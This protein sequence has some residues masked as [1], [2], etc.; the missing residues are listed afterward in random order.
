MKN[1]KLHRATT[2]LQ[3]KFRANKIDVIIAG[4]LLVIAGTVSGINMSGYPQRFEDEGTY[5]S[6]AYAVE[7]KH[8]LA[9]YT[10][11][12]D[13]PPVG[14]IQIAGYT[15]VTNAFA[16]YGS[17][18]SAGREYMLVLHLAT[19]GLL[20]ALARR[21]KI[22]GIA[23]GLG[24]LAYALS[25]LSVE[26]SRYVLLDNVA[27]PW[28]LAAFYLALSPKRSLGAAIG[29]AFCMA[30]AILSKETF[31]VLL[32]VLMYAMWQGSDK[33]NRRYMFTAFGVIFLMVTGF[34]VLYAALKNELIP[35]QGH[36]SL[37][38]SLAWQLSGRAG[39]GSIFDPNSGTRGL[40]K[41]WLNIDFWLMAAGV[42]TLP[43]SLIVRRLRPIGLSLLLGLALL[44]RT[45]YLPYPYIIILLPFAALTFAAAIHYLIVKPLGVKLKPLH[46]KAAIARVVAAKIGAGVAAL[47]I[48]GTS[49]F[50][51]TPQ[52]QP[53]LTAL[54]TVDNDQS[55][56]QA[57]DWVNQNIG[58]QNRLVVESALWTDLQDKGFNQPQ[59]VWLYKTETDPEVTKELGGWQG[60]DYIVLDGPTI[61]A[62][63]A[64]SFPTVYTAIAHSQIVAT[65]GQDNQKIVIYKVQHSK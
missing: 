58:R 30:I 60:I 47:L 61:S 57:V 9:H 64:K 1:S 15:T 2:W 23:A 4:V 56:R 54:M 49:V 24:A 29:S 33:R 25:P 35:G 46:D 14:W 20:Y 11:W 3:D 32:P 28:L 10:Y 19:I 31:L 38:G 55:S 63:S 8:E 44:L 53:K 50:Y 65:F 22:S 41:Y 7:K 16:R 48:L 17:A 52:W 51:I 18:I 62:N 26:F 43:V 45:G 59:P 40:V 34:Y 21:L 12:Y 39:S 27:L 13:H 36:V 6:Q 5:V 42:A 37:L